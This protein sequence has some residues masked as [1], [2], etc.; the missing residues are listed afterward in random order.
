MLKS[1]KYK[2]NKDTIKW[3]L[4]SAAPVR[5]N[6][7]FLFIVKVLQGIAGIAFALLTR[8]IIDNAVS[9]NRD[10]FVMYVLLG[11][12]LLVSE[13]GLYWLASYYKER[14][15]SLLTKHLREKV[16]RTILD[17][18]YIDVSKVHSGEWMTKINS[19]TSIIAN[20]VTAIIPGTA[21]LI[22]QLVCAFAAMF[23]V[24]PRLA[25]ILIPIGIVM[26]I[27][28]LFLRLKLKEY[29][30][31][32]QR[33][34]EL[35][36]SYLQESL[37]SMMIIR[38]YTQEQQTESGA[39]KRLND[40]VRIR[41]R[42]ARFIATCASAVYALI[43]LSYFIGMFICGIRLLDGV[44]TYG[45]MAAVLQLIR[46]ADAPLAEVTMAIPQFFNMTASAERLMAIEQ[47]DSEKPCEDRSFDETRKYYNI[48]FKSI[49]FNDVGFSYK[50]EGSEDVLNEFTAEINKGE[51]V[52]FT[53]ESGCGKSTTMSLMMGIYKPDRGSVEIMGSNGDLYNV[54][55]GWRALFAYVPQENM[56]MSGTIREIVSFAAPER[57]NDDKALHRA[58]RIACAEDFVQELPLGMDT[59]LGEH[60]SGLSEG[61]M[62]RIA[63]ARAIFSERPVLLL[64]EATSALDENTERQL[65][66]NL[67]NM[68]DMTVVIITHRPAALEICSKRICFKKTRND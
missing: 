43:R 19:D 23:V 11:C 38:A 42:R 60:G 15:A 44:I 17:R 40:V 51:Y 10:S 35:S 8:T 52:A 65:L 45:M 32:V 46:Q 62:Q 21:G 26:I 3:I 31:Q 34:E 25:W 5:G 48:D 24:L 50:T 9:G 56:L 14:P 20:A 22:V 2:I 58:L 57:A 30:K 28:S 66:E 12:L 54:D 18:S 6:L 55:A 7:W 49:R 27:V 4:Q 41:L 47:I 61:Q 1:E 68:T 37:E 33:Y 53:G 36:Y 64:D 39:D 16:F 13:I 63:V 67:K 59:K 29:H